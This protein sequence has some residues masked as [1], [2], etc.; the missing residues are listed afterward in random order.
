[1]QGVEHVSD[2]PGRI[3]VTAVAARS[4]DEAAPGRPGRPTGDAPTRHG[5]DLPDEPSERNTGMSA[6]TSASTDAS[7]SSA[8]PPEHVLVVGTG[9]DFPARLRAALPG[10]RTTVMCQLDY[11]DKVQ[12]PGANARVVGVRGD[13]PDEEWI[14]LAAAAHAVDPF[15]RIGTFGERD[16]G[17][18]AVVAEALGLPAHSPQTV[19]LVHDKAAMRVRLAERGVDTTASA[20]VDDL[21]ALRAFVRSVGGPCVVKPVSSSG[22]AGVT[23]VSG[24]SELTEAFELAAGSYMGLSSA[25]VLVEE[26]LTGPQFSVEAFSE[27]GEHVMIAVTR[28][29]SDPATFVELGHVSPADVPADTRAGIEA[30]VAAVLDAVGI[31]FG[32]SHTEVVLTPAGPRVIETHVRMGGDMIPT[33]A[34]EATGVDIDDCA[35]RQTL[36]EKVLPGIRARLAEGSGQGCSAIWFASVA[37]PGTL[38]EVVG[39]EEARALPDVTEV[40]PTARPGTQVGALASSESRVAYARALAPTEGEAVRAAKAAATALEFRLR[41]RTP[42]IETV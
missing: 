25:G 30:Y 41:V 3:F 19:T 1:M 20:R 7:A 27:G 29:Y 17:R 4:A 24:G 14:A 6:P 26:F 28:K 35:A 42:D 18:Y 2:A 10:T 39:L 23:K 21:A 9:R 8:S 13:A 38:E 16:Q 34:L 5:P 33:L 11:L 37:A 32:P 40:E 22:S 31:E 36:G 12:E 15:T